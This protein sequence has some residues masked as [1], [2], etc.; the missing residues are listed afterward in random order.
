MYG[1]SWEDKDGRRDD[2]VGRVL[3]F[4]GK[5]TGGAPRVRALGGP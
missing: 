1:R 2:D 4:D 3:K 5:D